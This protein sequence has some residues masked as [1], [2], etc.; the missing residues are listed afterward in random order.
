MVKLSRAAKQLYVAVGIGFAGPAEYMRV[1][2]AS[3]YKVSPM[4]ASDVAA[5]L[6][7][8]LRQAS[9]Q[10]LQAIKHNQKKRETKAIVGDCRR[11]RW[12]WR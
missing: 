2:R 7:D 6:V 3:L 4:L 12:Y 5:N 1:N 9:Q 8:A 10:F 11:P